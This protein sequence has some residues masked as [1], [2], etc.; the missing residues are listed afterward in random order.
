MP[1][2]AD[3][4]ALFARIRDEAS[5]RRARPAP[6][7]NPTLRCPACGSDTVETA[8]WPNNIEPVAAACVRCGASLQAV[9][10]IERTEP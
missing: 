5:G 1:G 2:L 4:D 9:V 8:A 6:K 3:A 10:L 7:L